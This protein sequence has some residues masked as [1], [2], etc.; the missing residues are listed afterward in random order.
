MDM[1]GREGERQSLE[2]GKMSADRKLLII[3]GELSIM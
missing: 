2:L 1:V 3:Q